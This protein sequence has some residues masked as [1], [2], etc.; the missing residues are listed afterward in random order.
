MSSP[1]Q[2]GIYCSFGAAHSTFPKFSL[3]LGAQHLSLAEVY[4]RVAVNAASFRASAGE[5]K[6]GT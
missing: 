1:E 2:F 6:Q 3:W 4:A 5:S